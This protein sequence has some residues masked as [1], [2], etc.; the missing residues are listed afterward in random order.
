MSLL[1]ESVS[2]LESV[3]IVCKHPV[4][5]GKYRPEELVMIHVVSA[6]GELDTVCVSMSYTCQEQMINIIY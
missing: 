5:S 3:L 4:V 6:C 2:L 1:V